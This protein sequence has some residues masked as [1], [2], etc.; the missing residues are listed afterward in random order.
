V[1]VSIGSASAA[2]PLVLGQSLVL[3]LN[4]HTHLGN[5]GAPTSPPVVPFTPA[6]LSAKNM[7]E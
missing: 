4:T 1:G 7:V 5:L 3:A 6:L 2:E